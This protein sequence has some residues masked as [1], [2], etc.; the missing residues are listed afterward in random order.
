MVQASRIH[1]SLYRRFALVPSRTA[2][3]MRVLQ[4]GLPRLN[5][6]LNNCCLQNNGAFIPKFDNWNKLTLT[7]INRR[8]L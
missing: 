1:V 3:P 4:T 6:S 2:L 7:G 8:F 5:T